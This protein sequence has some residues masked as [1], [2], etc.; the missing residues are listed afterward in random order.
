MTATRTVPYAPAD[1]LRRGKPPATPEQII[2]NIGNAVVQATGDA[3]LAYVIGTHVAALAQS[4]EY[5]T[6][7]RR[8][9]PLYAALRDLLAAA[10]GGVTATWERFVP[11]IAAARKALKGQQ[12]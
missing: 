1:T 5:Y 10:E 3:T 2:A 7:R 12:P 11:P 6:E 9:T 8:D 4:V